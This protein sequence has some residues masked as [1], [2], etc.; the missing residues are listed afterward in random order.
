MEHSP[1][2]HSSSPENNGGKTTN[3]TAS[4]AETEN[5][6]K[7]TDDVT[8]SSQKRGRRHSSSL[9]AIVG[10]IGIRIKRSSSTVSSSSDGRIS[11]LQSSAVGSLSTPPK[12]KNSSSTSDIN[13]EISSTKASSRR[14]STPINQRTTTVAS[15]PVSKN[16][17]TSLRGIF[18]NTRKISLQTDLI[19]DDQLPP[20]PPLFIKELNKEESKTIKSLNEFPKDRFNTG[21]EN[22][23]RNIGNGLSVQCNHPTK[24]SVF[25]TNTVSNNV[26]FN[27]MSD[28][29]SRVHKHSLQQGNKWKLLQQKVLGNLDEE[30]DDDQELGN[31][32]F[33]GKV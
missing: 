10:N 20:R 17:K 6:G 32:Q 14:R 7:T 12:R 18:T 21:D 27:A 16:K 28:R 2:H 33:Y 13:S 4:T 1:S 31:N 25:Q 24:S 19:G 11:S 29:R 8:D 15:L 22:Y 3:K 5:K 9:S 23:A 30:K 26:G